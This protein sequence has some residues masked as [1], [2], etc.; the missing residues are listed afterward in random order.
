MVE[1][2]SLGINITITPW[3]GGT[4]RDLEQL[5]ISLFHEMEIGLS[6]DDV[7]IH[8]ESAS[9]SIDPNTIGTISLL[10]LP[11]VAEKVSDTIIKWIEKRPECS[12][13][14]SIPVE[15]APPVVFTYNPNNTS[16]EKLRKWISSAVS[17][18]QLED[19]KS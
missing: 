17:Y 9:R 14:I 8:Q 4:L 19:N 11:I 6:G 10:L 1:S 15:G 13:T 5:R 18:T 16:P 7:E 3:E 12:V 2:D